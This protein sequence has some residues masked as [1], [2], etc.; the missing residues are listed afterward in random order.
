MVTRELVFAATLRSNIKG[1]RDAMVELCALLSEDMGRVVTPL[2]ALAPSALADALASGAAHFGWVSPT[3]VLMAQQLST[4]V[5]LLSSV[6]GGVAE[7]HTVLFTAPAS[8]LTGLER[9]R[10][11]RAAWV[12]PTSASGYLVIRKTLARKGVDLAAAFASEVFLGA[13]GS[14]GRRRNVRG[15]RAW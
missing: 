8:P 15:V 1:A 4:V 10:G 11:L 2:S 6:R 13:R 7:Y 14:R 3:L 5:P 9:L 12:A